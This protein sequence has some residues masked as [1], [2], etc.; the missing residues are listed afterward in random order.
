MQDELKLLKEKVDYL[1]N[2]N[3][4]SESKIEGF[5]QELVQLSEN[6]SLYAIRNS[7]I[8]VNIEFRSLK[9]LAI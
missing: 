6:I 1:E 2:E 8:S 4:V 5:G 9:S 7:I 3:K